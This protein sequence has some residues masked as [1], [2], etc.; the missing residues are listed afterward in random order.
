MKNAFG[1]FVQ[2]VLGVDLGGAEHYAALNEVGER[3][4]KGLGFAAPFKEGI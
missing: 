1:A 4:E 3:A 2:I